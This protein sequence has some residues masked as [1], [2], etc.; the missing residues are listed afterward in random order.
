MLVLQ[1][2]SQISFPKIF[3]FP[4]AN[5]SLLYLSPNSA[6][7]WYTLRI[8]YSCSQICH[9]KFYTYIKRI[10]Y[11]IRTHHLISKSSYSSEIGNKKKDFWFIFSSLSDS[12]LSEG[13]TACS[14]P[15]LISHN[16]WFSKA[17]V[18]PCLLLTWLLKVQ[19]LSLME[20]NDW[21]HCRCN[22]DKNEINNL[23]FYTTCY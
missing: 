3:V 14:W 22:V 7:F 13:G 11:A 4:H 17:E 23:N 8:P 6:T 15:T 18:S 20:R 5:V 10:K 9:S 1:I 12:L 21:S 16:S 19:R 2:T